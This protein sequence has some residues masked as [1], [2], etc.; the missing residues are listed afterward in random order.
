M[1]LEHKQLLSRKRYKLQEDMV[2]HQSF[3]EIGNKENNSRNAT[4]RR[5]GV[6]ILRPY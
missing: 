4:V 3:H 1:P 5:Y 6:A 2:S